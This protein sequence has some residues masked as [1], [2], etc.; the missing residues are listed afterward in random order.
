MSVASQMFFGFCPCVGMSGGGACVLFCGLLL[1]AD[2]V[3]MSLFASAS[4]SAEARAAVFCC[5]N[6]LSTMWEL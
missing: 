5:A 3:G 2:C 4:A 1:L 6:F